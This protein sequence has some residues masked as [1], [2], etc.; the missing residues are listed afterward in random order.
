MHLCSGKRRNLAPALTIGERLIVD[1][2]AFVCRADGLFVKML[3]VE[4]AAFD[5]CDLSTYQRGAVFKILRAILR[6]YFELF[7]VSCHCREMLLL[8]IVR[9]KIPRRSVGKRIVEAKL[10]RLEF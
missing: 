8:L 4:L 10:C 5:A 1:K 6:P 7:V 3:G 2:A 9:C